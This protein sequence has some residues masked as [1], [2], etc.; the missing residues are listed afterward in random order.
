[1]EILKVQADLILQL[2]FGRLVEE[3]KNASV[4]GFTGRITTP[5]DSYKVIYTSKLSS[6]SKINTSSSES[7]ELTIH[8]L[9]GS[10]SIAGS[11]YVGN[12]NPTQ[13]TS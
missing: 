6:L 9:L 3:S 8:I 12:L 4:Y 13:L 1:V 11:D 2:L 10:S 5:D 7:N